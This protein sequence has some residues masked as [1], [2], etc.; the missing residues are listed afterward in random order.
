VA[1]DSFCAWRWWSNY[2]Y[3]PCFSISTFI[4]SSCR[5]K[6][7]T[8]GASR[9]TMWR[10]T[11]DLESTHCNRLLIELI[12]LQITKNGCMDSDGSGDIAMR[13][14][15]LRWALIWPSQAYGEHTTGSS[16]A[17]ITPALLLFWALFTPWSTV[18]RPWALLTLT[19]CHK[20]HWFSRAC[21]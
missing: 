8:V 21:L 1:A 20:P 5:K 6:Q 16:Q 18:S 9:P 12:E 13:R 19:I 4:S 11:Y 10:S 3:Q 2:Q 14:F 7:G 15:Q 17:L